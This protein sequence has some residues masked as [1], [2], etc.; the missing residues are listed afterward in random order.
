MN[1]MKI[2]VAGAPG[3]G[4]DASGFLGQDSGVLITDKWNRDWPTP[5]T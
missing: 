2:A 4:A 3:L 1:Q 5:T